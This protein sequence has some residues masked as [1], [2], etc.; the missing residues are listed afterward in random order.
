MAPTLQRSDVNNQRKDSWQICKLL[1]LSN[2]VN[3][4]FPHSISE[5][6]DVT[7]PTQFVYAH[8]HVEPFTFCI[9]I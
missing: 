5:Q 8:S 7:R 3:P 1:I 9:D 4:Y 2:S 6:Q